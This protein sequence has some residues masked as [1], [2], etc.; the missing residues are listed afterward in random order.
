[1]RVFPI[2]LALNQ[3]M[4]IN[5]LCA[6]IFHILRTMIDRAKIVLKLERVLAP[7]TSIC[8]VSS[9][10]SNLASVLFLV[11][12]I[13]LCA[14]GTDPIYIYASSLGFL[15]PVMIIHIVFRDASFASLMI[16]FRAGV[17]STI[18]IIKNAFRLL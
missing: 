13:G 2:A 10:S 14:I 16:V 9:T 5:A 1:M 15:A 7:L 6:F 8:T 3:R 12:N 17:P 4:I 18:G 11:I